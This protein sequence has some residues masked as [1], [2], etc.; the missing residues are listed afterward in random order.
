MSKWD[1]GR[2][3]LCAPMLHRNRHPEM[4]SRI[5]CSL[6]VRPTL[7]ATIERRG[8]HLGR[9]LTQ[10]KLNEIGFVLIHEIQH[11]I[12]ELRRFAVTE[13]LK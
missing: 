12:H 10:E 11:R 5:K 4:L 2:T 9:Q 8:V 7:M 1:A 3:L 13:S 6:P